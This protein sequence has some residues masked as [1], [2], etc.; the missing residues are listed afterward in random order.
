MTN[1][2]NFRLVSENKCL[3]DTFFE[4]L[5]V[6]RGLDCYE[7]ELQLRKPVGYMNTHCIQNHP[8]DIIIHRYK[9]KL[10]N[11]KQEIANLNFE[12]GDLGIIAQ[13]LA[14]ERAFLAYLG[15]FSV[16]TRGENFE[17]T[18]DGAK[19]F[20]MKNEL[21]EGFD[22]YADDMN[23]AL[24]WYLQDDWY[25]NSLSVITLHNFLSAIMTKIG[26]FKAERDPLSPIRNPNFVSFILLR[27]N[28]NYE[29]LL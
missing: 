13:S 12:K 20:K 17:K 5:N 25:K 21:S 8:N 6:R 1:G 11:H 4:M 10:C 24:I 7:Q 3:A 22:H 27:M 15:Y 16:A 14:L 28:G 9:L 23:R 19:L 18:L 29:L 2:V 26:G